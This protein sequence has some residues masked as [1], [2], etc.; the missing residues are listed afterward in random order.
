[1]HLQKPLFWSCTILRAALIEYNSMWF[2]QM[3]FSWDTVWNMQWVYENYTPLLKGQVLSYI[4]KKQNKSYQNLFDHY[5]KVLG[6]KKV[7]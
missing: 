3:E 2:S 1:M 4:I 5:C 6:E 7:L